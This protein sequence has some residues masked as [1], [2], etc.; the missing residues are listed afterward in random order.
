VADGLLPVATNSS[1]SRARTDRF[2]QYREAIG[3]LRVHGI[4]LGWRLEVLGTLNASTQ[5]LKA[6]RSTLRESD[7][8]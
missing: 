7:D 8:A 3:M 5:V 2:Y 1:R 6:R 4:W